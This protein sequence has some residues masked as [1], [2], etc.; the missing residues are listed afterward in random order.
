MDR[1]VD[2]QARY[3]VA[4]HSLAR[5]GI[6]DRDIPGLINLAFLSQDYYYSYTVVKSGFCTL[7]R[8]DSA[9]DKARTCK[10]VFSCRLS[11]R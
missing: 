9:A 4:G 3:L 6:N 11:S 8:Y 7:M 5:F 1:G 10:P 2:E